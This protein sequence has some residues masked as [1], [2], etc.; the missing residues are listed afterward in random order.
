VSRW[1]LVSWVQRLVPVSNGCW[2]DECRRLCLTGA[3]AEDRTCTTDGVGIGYPVC[4]I[5]AEA[6]TIVTVIVVG[7]S[8]VHLVGLVVAD[9]RSGVI[10]ITGGVSTNHPL[11]LVGA[12]VRAV[13]L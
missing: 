9:A 13:F 12:E 5:D 2:F 4:P 10:V 3:D 8:T 11:G 1:L 6:R 7:V